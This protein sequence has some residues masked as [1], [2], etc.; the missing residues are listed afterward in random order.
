VNDTVL[1]RDIGTD[2]LS[3]SVSGHDE[4]SS[5]VSHEGHGGSTGRGGVETVR[6]ERRVDDNSSDNVARKIE[7]WLD[8]GQIER[9][10]RVVLT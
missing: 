2:D 10:K 4:D 1:D 6:D 3:G 7:N 8:L 5:I 9:T